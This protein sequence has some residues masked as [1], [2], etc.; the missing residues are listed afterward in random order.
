MA[1]ILRE[2]DTERGGVTIPIASLTALHHWS[3]S[4]PFLL[5]DTDA[6]PLPASRNKPEAVSNET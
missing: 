5:G 6:P 4:G 3:I 1:P 2:I